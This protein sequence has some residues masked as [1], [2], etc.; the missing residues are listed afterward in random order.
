MDYTIYLTLTPYICFVLIILLIRIAP[1]W[2]YGGT[3]YLFCYF[4][5]AEGFLVFN[6]LELLATVDATKIVFAQIENVC[7]ALIPPFW[8][9]F[10]LYFTGRRSWT[11]IGTFWPMLFP[12]FFTVSLLLTNPIHH[13][14]WSDVQIVQVG[15]H[16][17]LRITHGI[18]YFAAVILNYALVLAG[19]LI[20]AREFFKGRTIYRRQLFWMT[21]GTL[22]GLLSNVV[23]VFRILPD[24]N[25]DFTP[26]GIAIGAVMF[27]VGIQRHGLLE[28]VPTPRSRLFD[29]L[30]DGVVVVDGRRRIVDVNKA[31]MGILDINEADLGLSI[32]ACAPL[33]P[34]FDLLRSEVEPGTA[35]VSV[36]TLRYEVRV[37]PLDGG[38]RG[39]KG[40]VMVLHDVTER[41]RMYEEIRT[42]RGILPICARCKKIR[43]DRGFWQSV[44]T[45]VSEHSHAEFSHGLCPD[46]MSELY[47]DVDK[48]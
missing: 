11:R 19:L 15:S 30:L 1:T 42:L 8:L 24:V 43:S 14:F 41:S 3:K 31:A 7:I 40:A 44:E 27:G 34:V 26:V 20:V 28:L 10:V 16:R 4:L 48:D 38:I 46:C 33:D 36:N 18:L 12:A 32:F 39:R 23:Y 29:D 25:K 9:L 17:A 37:S 45:Y 6:Y 22:V 13:L 5:A 47:P 2:R 21:V 35:D